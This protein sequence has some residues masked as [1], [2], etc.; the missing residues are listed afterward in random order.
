MPALTEFIANHAVFTLYV[1][2]MLSAGTILLTQRRSPA[3]TLAWLFAF[4]AIPLVSGLY[5]IFFGPRRLVR[6]RKRYWRG[7]LA[8][9]AGVAPHL[10][11]ECVPPALPAQSAGLAALGERLAQGAPSCATGL[12][13]LADGDAYLDAI[14]LAIADARHHVHAEYY[15]WEPDRVGARMRDALAAAARRGVAVRVTI[16]GVGARAADDGFW[17]PLLDA[18]GRVARFNPLR[19]TLASFNF[20][21]F[22]THRKIM[23]CDGRVG[24]VGGNNLHD[25]I[26]ATQRPGTAWR[27]VHLRIAG[28]PVRRLQHLFLENWVYSGGEIPVSA[29]N[30]DAYFPPLPPSDARAVQIVAS[31]PDDERAAIHAF[32]FASIGAARSRVWIQTPYLIPDEPMETALRIAA[33]RGVDVRVIVPRKGD[34]WI[35]TRA[36]RTYCESLR[37][38]GVKIFEYLPAMLHAKT[39]IVDD[40]IAFIGTANMDNRSFRLNFEVGAACFDPELVAQ[41]AHRFVEDREQSEAF[42]LRRHDRFAPLIESIARLCSPIL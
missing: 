10:K 24:F 29:A 23:V 19:F 39:M 25:D 28:G 11:A 41:L 14:T 22:R 26:S 21:N 2:W 18:G 36:S 33:Q 20:A 35:V 31:G 5:Y 40:G 3:A 6:R 38:A 9:A 37:G 34:S 42:R 7:R 27:D 1:V 4:A 16:D 30:C 12:T 32:L 15:I 8:L 17:Q 13:L